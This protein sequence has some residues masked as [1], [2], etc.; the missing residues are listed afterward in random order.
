MKDRLLVALSRLFIAVCLLISAPVFTAPSIRISYAQ[1]EKHVESVSGTSE[2]TWLTVRVLPSVRQ[3]TLRLLAKITSPTTQTVKDEKSLRLLIRQWYGNASSK[4]LNIFKSAN[5]SI[6]LGRTIGEAEILLPGNPLWYFNIKKAIPQGSSIWEQANLE[7]G[8]A[9]PKT[10][11]DIRDANPSLRKASKL[12]ADQVITFPYVTRSASLR[13]SSAS[14]EEMSL[15]LNKLKSDPAVLIAETGHMASLISHWGLAQVREMGEGCAEVPMGD[16]WPFQISSPQDLLQELTR[17]GSATVAILDSGII[18]NDARF[19]FWQNPEPNTERGNYHDEDRCLDDLIGCNFLTREG[20]PRDDL[21]EPDLY[22]HGT[23]VSG[24]ASGRL[25]GEPF[26]SELNQRIKLMILKVA[27]PDGKVL[28]G[29]INNAITYAINKRAA[30]VNMSLEGPYSGAVAKQI[31]E[32]R[33][34]LFVVAAGNGRNKKNGVDIDDPMEEVFPAQLSRE[35]ENVIAVAAHDAVGRRAC[36]SN[37]GGK[38]VDIAAPGVEIE[39]TIAGGTAKLSGTS[40][41]A[42]LVTLLAGLLYSQ[43]I[44][45]PSAI[46]HRILSSA[47]FQPELKDKVTSSG[48]LNLVKALNICSD[49]IELSDHSLLRGK[50]LKPE[51]IDLPNEAARTPFRFVK[52]LVNNPTL[53]PNYRITLLKSGKLRHVYASLEELSSVVI[54]IGNEVKEI[55]I[56]NIIDII[57]AHFSGIATSLCAKN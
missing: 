45:T 30:V 15:V 38:T 49:L 57:P 8:I 47:D 9:G 13:L 31:R 27:G 34:V 19:A 16:K 48:K 37:F 5:P 35:Q 33:T 17:T 42:P 39:S 43:G 3:E 24:I 4:I 23:H 18:E 10:V 28:S 54:Q 25:L 52:K 26:L 36:F 53:S 7:I 2:D 29:D 50:I 12:I 32:S 44:T 21:E 46:K 41:A 51:F 14:S 6:R 56:S 55:P 11:Q 20:F 22:N 40:Q 1:Q